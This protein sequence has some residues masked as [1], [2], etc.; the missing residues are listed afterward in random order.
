M[1]ERLAEAPDRRAGTREMTVNRT[2]VLS[3]AQFPLASD[4]AAPPCDEVLYWR[5][6]P[7]PEI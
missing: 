3:R 7:K 1:G 5:R 4:L 2:A 6:Q